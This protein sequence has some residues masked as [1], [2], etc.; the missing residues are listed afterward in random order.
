[1]SVPTYIYHTLRFDEHAVL[2]HRLIADVCV[3]EAV[4]VVQG[5]LVDHGWMEIGTMM[6]MGPMWAIHGN[7]SN[8]WI[9]WEGSAPKR[10]ER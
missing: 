3:V 1:M 2:L 8:P 6:E 10:R 7:R 4:V 9:H 5:V